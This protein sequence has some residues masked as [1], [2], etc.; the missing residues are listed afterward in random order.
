MFSHRSP[1][2]YTHQNFYQRVYIPSMRSP[3]GWTYQLQTWIS[4][5]DQPSQTLSTEIPSET[6]PGWSWFFL[7]PLPVLWLC[8]QI[9]D[10]FSPHHLMESLDTDHWYPRI[11]GWTC[12]PSFQSSGLPT[13]CVPSLIHNGSGIHWSTSGLLV[14]ISGCEVI[15]LKRKIS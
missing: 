5:E 9:L 10:S 11:H 6:H 14:H 3:H 7:Q 15:I 12:V 8:S 2:A 13:A 4:E 1:S